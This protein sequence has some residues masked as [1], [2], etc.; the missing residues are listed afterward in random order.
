MNTN[1][2]GDFSPIAIWNVS[3]SAATP[4]KYDIVADSQATGTPGVFDTAD[5]IANPGYQGFTVEIISPTATFTADTTDGAAPLTV[6]FTDQSTG[7]APLTYAWDFNNDGTT[8]STSQNPSYSYTVPGTYS[9][10]LS[11]SNKGGSQQITKNNYITVTKAP[12]V[13]AFTADTTSGAAPLTVH[14][15]DHSTGNPTAWAWDF[16]GDGSA[17]STA[18]NPAYTYT[19]PGNYTVKLTV[20]NTGGN[21]SLTKSSYINVTIP[22][23]TLISSSDANG[24]ISPSGNFNVNQGASQEFTINANT[25]YHIT[26]VWVDGISEGAVSSYTFTDVQS[27]HTISAGFAA[28]A[29]Y[30]TIAVI[31]DTQYYSESFP[32]IFDKQAQWIVDNT[33]SQNIIFAA[34]LGDLVQD[35]D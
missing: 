23:F 32:A 15:T 20:S 6:H 2:S 13:A 22:S 9:V 24:N 30:F 12:P 35:Y 34:H 1:S 14:F 17:T 7:T 16:K 19:T 29:D 26:D 33:Q 18:Q 8:D 5:Y 27:A 10:S 4:A 3:S 28:D 25:G 21:N 31:P 11:V